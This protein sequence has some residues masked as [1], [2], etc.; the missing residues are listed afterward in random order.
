MNLLLLVEGERIEPV[1]YREW[2]SHLFPYLNFVSRPEDLVGNSCRIIPGNGYPNMVSTPKSYAGFSRLEAC[3]RDIK[4]YNNVDYF[5]ICVDSEEETYQSRFNEISL[6][7]DRL[8]L[9]L[10][11]DTSQ[12]TQFFIII[13]TCCIET[14]ALGNAQIPFSISIFCQRHKDIVPSISTILRCFK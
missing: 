9:Q 13:Q 1:V 4:N 8:K 3:L 6:K 7:L 10:N 5:L 11:I 12:S 14:W 2:L